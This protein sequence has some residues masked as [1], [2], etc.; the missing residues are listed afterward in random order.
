[1]VPF[2]G[3]SRGA[4]HVLMLRMRRMACCAPNSAVSRAWDGS[5]GY[6][7]CTF[8]RGRTVAC[9]RR[10]RSG[11]EHATANARARRR[12]ARRR[13]KSSQVRLPRAGHGSG[14]PGR[15]L[16]DRVPWFRWRRTLLAR[17]K[18]GPER[19]SH[20]WSPARAG[21]IC[22]DFR[23]HQP[24]RSPDV[25]RMAWRRRAESNR[26]TRICNPATTA[27]RRGRRAHFDAGFDVSVLLAP[28]CLHAWPPPWR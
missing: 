22:D 9:A 14:L 2:L 26:S 5:R 19:V 25:A 3:A 1:V 12:R 17:W 10:R 4:A 15:R 27:I 23:R 24:S 8:G 18:R 6:R 21:T 20:S 11:N 28:P 7:I 16:H 13:E